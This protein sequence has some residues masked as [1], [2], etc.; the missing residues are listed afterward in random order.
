MTRREED[1]LELIRKNPRIS[2]NEIADALGITRSSVGVHISNLMKKGIILGKEYILKQ[3]DYACVLGGCNIDIIG[4]PTQKLIARDSNPG[5]VKISHGGVGRN[6]AEN[7][8]HL[9]VPTKLISA[10]GDDLYGKKILDHA[11]SIGLDMKNTLVLGGKST[12]TYL[13]VL[14]RQGDMQLAISHMDILN[15]ISIEFIQTVRPVIEGAKFCVIDTNIPENVIGYVLDNFKNMVFF[16]DTV[17]TA[18]AMKVK[19]KIGAFHT[20]KPNKIEAELLSGIKIEKEE[21]L[22]KASEYFLSQGVKRVFITLG[23]KGVFFQDEKRHQLIPNPQI[24]VVNATGAGDAFLAGLAYCYFHDKD[25]EESA[26]FAMT[27]AILAL[28]HEDTINPGISKENVEKKM[29]EIGLC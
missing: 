16:L 25:T 17:S 24:S 13:A 5:R 9:G 7:M 19:N 18:K 15:E 21:D 6:I 1:L 4:F 20:I 2:Q 11:A 22:R 26:R 27:A 3:E 14:D 12:S 8:V 23:E 10:V 28:S 29:K